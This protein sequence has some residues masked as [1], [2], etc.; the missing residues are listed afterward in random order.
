MQERV[1]QFLKNPQVG[2]EKVPTYKVSFCS[3]FL[4]QKQVLG[5]ESIAIEINPVNPSTGFPTKKEV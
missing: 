5:K 3:N 4:T 2:R 1:T